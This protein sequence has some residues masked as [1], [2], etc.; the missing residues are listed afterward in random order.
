MYLPVSVVVPLYNAERHIKDVTEAIFSQDYPAPLEIIV[1]ND[2]SRDRSLEIVK[3]LKDRGDLKIIDQPNQGAVTATNNGFKVAKYD[4]ICSVDSDVVLQ[5]DWLRKITEEFDDPAVGA[6]QGYY[7]T[8]HDVSFLAKM[9]GYDVEARYDGIA[10]KYVTHVCTGN[11]AYRKSALDKA[12]LFDPAFKYGYDN[13]MSYRL[14]K[15]G[16]KLVFRKDALCDHYWKADIKGYLKQQYWSAYGRMQLVQKHKEK[17]AGDS[18]SGLRMILQVPLTLLF[19]ILLISSIVLVIFRFPYNYS[20]LSA[21][22]VLGIIL[23]DRF[24]FAFSV[25]EKQK[26][27]IALLL[28]FIHLLRNTVWCWAFIRWSAKLL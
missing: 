23:L 19:F 11:T 6:V 14:Q 20:L 2:G 4:I 8:P 16:Y 21:F 27:F 26:T 28:P 18:V 3:G 5:K 10:S 17:I 12:G 1:V 24:I 13:D 25:L 22:T 9:M 15:A 7:K